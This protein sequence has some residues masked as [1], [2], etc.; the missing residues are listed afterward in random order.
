MPLSLF[1]NLRTKHTVYTS[2]YRGSFPRRSNYNRVAAGN[3]PSILLSVRATTERNGTRRTDGR[4]INTRRYESSKNVRTVGN[5]PRALVIGLVSRTRR[6]GRIGAGRNSPR[7]SRRVVSLREV[8][9]ELWQRSSQ[10]E[11]AC[12]VHFKLLGIYC[13]VK[14]A[15]FFYPGSAG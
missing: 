15:G 9:P 8:R 1:G 2:V 3:S 12:I 10:S 6:I 7:Y 5:K 14:V 13:A 11:S 4:S